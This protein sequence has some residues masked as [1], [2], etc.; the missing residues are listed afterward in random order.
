MSS[1]SWAVVEPDVIE[2]ESVRSVR[3]GLIGGRVDV[4]GRDEPGARIEVHRVTGRPLEVSLVDGEL[5]VGYPS[6]LGSWEGLLDRL[7]AFVS[8]E[9]AADLHLAVPREVAVRLGT[10]TADGLLADVGGPASVTTVSGVLVTDSTRGS[11]SARSVSG[12]LVLRAR[13]PRADGW[14]T[15]TSARSPAR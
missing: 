4:I 2:L 6:T 13:S 12:D 8:R 1:E 3:V 9:D 15:W 14:A 7:R 11:L 10:V 5:K